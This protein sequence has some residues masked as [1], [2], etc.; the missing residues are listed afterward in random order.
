MQKITIHNFGPIKEC[1]MNLA[2]F[3]V[4][5][6]AQAAGKSTIAKAIYYFYL[7]KELCFDFI[8]G[9][10]VKDIGKS[11]SDILGEF[12]LHIFYELFSDTLSKSVGCSLEY[13]Y[14]ENTKIQLYAE[15]NDS[16]S[17]NLTINFSDNIVELAKRYDER[18]LSFWAVDKNSQ[19]LNRE[20]ENIFDVHY[21]PLYIPAGRS[22]VTMMTDFMGELLL[23]SGGTRSRSAMQ[24]LDYATQKYVREVLL[25]RKFFSEGTMKHIERA[26]QVRN[27]NA[28]LFEKFLLLSMKII[29]GE[30]FYREGAEFLRV[31]KFDGKTA[32]VWINFVSSGQQEILWVCN[33]MFYHLFHGDRVF[34]ILEEPEAHLYPDS[35]KYISEL[36]G[37]FV[38][39]GNRAII[40][41]HSPYILG[42]FNNL[43]YANEIQG[44]DEQRNE[45]VDE[46]KILPYDDSRAFYVAD[47]FVKDAMED[48]LIINSLIDGASDEINAENDRLIELK[49]ATEGQNEN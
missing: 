36:I 34:I 13:V 26:R 48:H 17:F 25:L 7:V 30:Y 9:S 12:L 29:K 6:G 5:T 19:Q 4:L 39:V 23:S 3:I 43:I 11:K 16:A 22:V 20:L 35:Q 37:L 18:D 10:K 31:K 38:H 33:I 27:S 14:T 28:W 8:I 21:K 44:V 24:N 40:T 1:E 49:W 32:D 42:E 45:I 2:Q 46:E 41:T 47:G 15:E